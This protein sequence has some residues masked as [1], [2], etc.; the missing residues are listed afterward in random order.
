[1][2]YICHRYSYRYRYIYAFIPLYIYIYVYISA[3]QQTRRT[4]GQSMPSYG[5]NVPASISVEDVPAGLNL[6][7]AA[8]I[9]DIDPD[10]VQTPRSGQLW[11][12]TSLL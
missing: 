6:R 3:R 4:H 1:M 10:V 11:L 12:S 2:P 9:G 8:D 7:G 5:L